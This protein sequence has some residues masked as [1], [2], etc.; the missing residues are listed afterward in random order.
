MRGTIRHLDAERVV[1]D[2]DS[3]LVRELTGAYAA[4]HL[5]HAYALT[6]HGMRGATVKPRASS[7]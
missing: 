4:E 2:T 1:I 3:G 5:E 7:S 6:G